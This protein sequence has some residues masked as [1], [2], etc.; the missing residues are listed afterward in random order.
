MLY[1]AILELVPH[2][3]T[4]HVL[5]ARPKVNAMANQAKG[6]TDQFVFIVNNQKHRFW[7]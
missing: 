1:S 3:T 6:K 2:T 5:D 4:L 7:I